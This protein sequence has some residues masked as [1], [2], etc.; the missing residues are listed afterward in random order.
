MVKRTLAEEGAE[1]PVVFRGK[2]YILHSGW[3]KME[4]IPQVTDGVKAAVMEMV[5]GWRGF[6]IFV[7]LF[8]IS[9]K[10]WG[11]GFR[12][13]ENYS[14]FNASPARSLS[15]RN[16]RLRPPTRQNTDQ[17]QTGKQPFYCSAF[18][19]VK[20]I[21]LA[22]DNG[23]SLGYL[24]IVQKCTTPSESPTMCFLPLCPTAT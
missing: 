23:R 7:D 3:G 2:S 12:F 11:L 5:R 13:F 19:S 9:R 15:E 10:T 24:S 17:Q 20:R 22:A 1:L 21:R 4:E 16:L 18:M 6:G 14:A 8:E